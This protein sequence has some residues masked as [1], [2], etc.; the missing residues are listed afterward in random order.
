MYICGKCNFSICISVILPISMQKTVRPQSGPGKKKN[1]Q[2]FNSEAYR[3]FSCPPL[4]ILKSAFFRGLRVYELKFRSKKDNEIIFFS[5]ES[6]DVAFFKS[7]TQEASRR[8]PETLF[9]YEI[10][11]FFK[12]FKKMQ[13]FQIKIELREASWVSDLE[14][15]TSQLS[16]EKKLS[17]YLV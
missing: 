14:K 11:K 5:S 9:W 2:L 12:I 3:D 7:A 10:L 16:L 15:A 17:L 8:L 1:S 13:N 6:W 4:I